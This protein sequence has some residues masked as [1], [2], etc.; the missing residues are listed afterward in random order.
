MSQHIWNEHFSKEGFM[1][2][3][4]ANAFVQEHAHLIKAQGEVLC[5]AE[6]EGRNAIFLAQEDFKVEALDASEVGL[7]K[8][9]ARAKE[10]DLSIKASL[11]DLAHWQPKKH[12]N[13]IIATFMHLNEPLRTQTFKRAIDA[14]APKGYL[15]MEFFSKDQLLKNFPSGGPKDLQL[16]YSVEELEP[17]FDRDDLIVKQL[18]Q[19]EDVL[20]E[21]W[22][23]QGPASLIRVI[24]QKR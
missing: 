16:L 21:G 1:Y 4:E 6:G 2:G 11:T 24:V 15:I 23:H 3:L 8:L 12:Y 14:L 17:I 19:E 18:D 22:G 10:L 20:D 13:A 7:S 9:L 5:L